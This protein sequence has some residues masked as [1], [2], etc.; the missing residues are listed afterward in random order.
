MSSP[1]DASALAPSLDDLAALAEAAFAALPDDFRKMTGDVIFR[2][3]EFAGRDVLD[4]LGIED[5]FELTGLYQG[6][7][8]GRRTVFDPSPQPSMIF[9]Y[10]RAILDEWVDRG[11]VTLAELV[12]HVLVHEIGHHFGLS[13]D[14]IDAIERE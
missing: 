2:V 12:S 6:V 10:R 3:D 14:H 5:A 11:D 4:E 1:P 13:D 8:I 9:L 7:D